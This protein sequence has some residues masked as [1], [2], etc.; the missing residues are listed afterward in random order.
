MKQNTTF[1]LAIV[2]LVNLR[3]SFKNDLVHVRRI[4]MALIT[5][6]TN[7]GV[8]TYVSHNVHSGF[9]TAQAVFNARALIF[10]NFY[11][12]RIKSAN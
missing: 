9:Y 6:H 12:R 5:V 7:M 4:V 1:N 8:H 11:V 3:T 10:L 2:F